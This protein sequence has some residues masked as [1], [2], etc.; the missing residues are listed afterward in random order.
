MSDMVDENGSYTLQ[1]GWSLSGGGVTCFALTD[2]GGYAAFN[3]NVQDGMGGWD[4]MF[5]L[6]TGGY[7]LY[8][9][10][11]ASTMCGSTQTV[12]SSAQTTTVC[13]VKPKIGGTVTIDKTKTKGGKGS[14]MVTATFTTST[15]YTQKGNAQI[16]ILKKGG[17]VAFTN[18]STP[19]GG[20]V[21]VTNNGP[22]VPAGTYTVYVLVP[23]VD[24][25]CSMGYV[26]SAAFDITVT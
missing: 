2:G 26:N 24:S 21:T 6:P 7:S 5:G 11:E 1:C 4:S 13:G 10:M 9:V 17:G 25:V 19:M 8:G 18:T 22:G 14:Y 3:Q 15:G 20:T 23:Y 12:N 16:L